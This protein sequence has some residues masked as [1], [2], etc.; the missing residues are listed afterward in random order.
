MRARVTNCR[1]LCRWPRRPRTGYC[2]M[3]RTRCITRHQ[4]VVCNM[5]MIW[6]IP[7]FFSPA[8]APRDYSVREF[9]SAG[10][11]RR[12]KT[13]RHSRISAP[14][15]WAACRIP[16]SYMPLICSSRT[17]S[18]CSAK[19]SRHITTG[20]AS[21]TERRSRRWA[22]KCSLATAVFIIGCNCRKA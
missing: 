11:L 3:K 6:I 2:W 12:N 8:H 7:T 1:I 21:D 5:L 13:S 15:A 4:S 20:S 22:S 14:L 10:S 19:R 9:V 16:A 17:G 18:R